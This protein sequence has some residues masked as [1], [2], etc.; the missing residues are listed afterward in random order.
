MLISVEALRIDPSLQVTLAQLLLKLHDILL[1]PLQLLQ[2]SCLEISLYVL[3]IDLIDGQLA[4]VIFGTIEI[5]LSVLLIEVIE[6]IGPKLL[7][8][9]GVLVALIKDVVEN[10]FSFDVQ[11]EVNAPYHMGCL[12][13]GLIA[14]GEV[15]HDDELLEGIVEV[16]LVIVEGGVLSPLDFLFLLRE[17]IASICQL[18]L[19]SAVIYRLVSR[20]FTACRGGPL[21]FY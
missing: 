12:L 7:L 8:V 6:S 16:F 18:L 4:E 19:P 15:R 13:V 2:L 10:S 14:V 3:L 1:E 9:D 20:S 21:H 17:L 5:L 11:G